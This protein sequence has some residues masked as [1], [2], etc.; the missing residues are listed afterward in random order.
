MNPNA[1]TRK[2][3]YSFSVDGWMIDEV[4]DRGK[5]AQEMQDWNLEP[6]RTFV[7]L[8]HPTSIHTESKRNCAYLIYFFWLMG[9]SSTTAM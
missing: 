3:S 8:S 1:I 6:T 5:V 4:A 2:V 9:Y 7:S